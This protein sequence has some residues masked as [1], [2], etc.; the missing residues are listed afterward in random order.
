MTP[1]GISI[2]GFPNNLKVT[3]SQ[4]WQLLIVFYI[5]L[6][7]MDGARNS[8]LKIDG[9]PVTHEAYLNGATRGWSD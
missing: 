1:L 6:I 7:K 5:N 4:F 8:F 3:S 9:F 2:D